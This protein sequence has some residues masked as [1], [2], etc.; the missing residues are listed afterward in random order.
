VAAL[1]IA[2]LGFRTLPFASSY[3]GG[4]NLKAWL[5]IYLIDQDTLVDQL[6]YR[7]IVYTSRMCIHRLGGQAMNKR[8]NI[9]LPEQTVRL[10]DRVAGK[11]QRS[12]LIDQAV[13]RYV[14]QEGRTN[15]RKL[16]QE[17]ARVRA[18]RD[19]QLAAEW[20]AVDEALPKTR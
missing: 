18:E 13:H 15:L 7:C 2:M 5:P 9:T 14:E 4:G 6:M 8:L 19:V 12:R 10:M 11:G 1:D 17:G 16:L 20:F 3:V